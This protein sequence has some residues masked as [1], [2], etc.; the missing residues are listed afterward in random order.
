MVIE[1]PILGAVALGAG[2]VLERFILKKKEMNVK[3]Y[4][5][6]SF[7]AIVLATL[8]L[9]YF[10]WKLDFEAFTIKNILIFAG[11]IASA[12]VANILIFYSE[13]G[14]EITKLEPARILEPLFTILL[15][16]ALSFF[17]GGIYESNIKMIILSLI[18]AVALIFPYVKKRH[19]KINKYIAASVLGS[20]FF[21]LELV[22]SGLILEFYSPVTFYFFRCLFVLAVSSAIFKPSFKPLKK[23]KNS[24]IIFVTGIVWVLY[25][26]IV[27]FGYLNYGVIF[28]TLMLMLGPIFVYILAFIFLK[29]RCSW[30]NVASSVIILGCVIIAV[31]TN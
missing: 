25:R 10:F 21:A 8:P 14:E 22:L 7:L 29:E 26:I 2:T 6:A 20:F 4:Q 28:T 24:L 12:V 17:V 18:S 16:I 5:V 31:L 27:Y 9:L 30:K 13:K 3:F 1:I 23:W 19:L 15:A 11:V